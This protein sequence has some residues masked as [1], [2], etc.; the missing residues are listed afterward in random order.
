MMMRHYSINELE[1][2][3]QRAVEGDAEAQE[4]WGLALQHG[5][6]VEADYEEARRWYQRAAVQGRSL[7]KGK[8]GWVCL[9]GQAGVEQDTEKGLSLLKSAMEAG[10][11]GAYASMSMA[12]LHGVGV[13]I[14]P[15]SAVSL[16]RRAIELG[17]QPRNRLA[18]AW[19]LL[20]RDAE[21]VDISKVSSLYESVLADEDTDLEMKEFASE[22]LELMG[23][24][25]AANTLRDELRESSHVLGPEAFKQAGEDF[26]DGVDEILHGKTTDGVQPSTLIQNYFDTFRKRQDK[27]YESYT[28]KNGHVVSHHAGGGLDLGYDSHTVIVEGDETPYLVLDQDGRVQKLQPGYKLDEE[29]LG[30]IDSPLVCTPISVGDGIELV[31]YIP[32]RDGYAYPTWEADADLEI[33]AALLNAIDDGVGGF[34]AKGKAGYV[35]GRSLYRV[36]RSTQSFLDDKGI[37]LADMAG[38]LSE[39]FG[40]LRE[41]LLMLQSEI[42]EGEDSEEQ[43]EGFDPWENEQSDKDAPLEEPVDF[44]TLRE[45]AF[46]TMKDL[47]PVM[48][49]AVNDPDMNMGG[50]PFFVQHEERE[51]LLVLHED[52][53][54]DRLEEEYELPDGSFS[55]D[56]DGLVTVEVPDPLGVLRFIQVL[57]ETRW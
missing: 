28:G 8:I 13:E 1:Q 53:S 23:K 33:A 20:I 24:I 7:S 9:V 12:Y 37:A 19:S 49:G 54:V 25:K 29:S 21:N 56:V 40:S 22:G 26:L 3:K 41:Q 42:L 38:E 43:D 27:W 47:Y 18:L 52:G 30:E 11:A 15:E 2:L 5:D 31:R 34:S 46:Q 4:L 6:G 51:L 14:N 55:Q 17:P 44:I 16:A 32:G 39:T 10:D 48:Q 45:M 36:A 35:L 50:F 57:P